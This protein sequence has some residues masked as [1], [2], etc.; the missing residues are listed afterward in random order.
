[1]KPLTATEREV[2]LE[3]CREIAEGATPAVTIPLEWLERYELL[4]QGLEVDMEEL[5]LQQL[6]RNNG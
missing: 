4:V 5:L 1:M 6:V 3:A 2:I